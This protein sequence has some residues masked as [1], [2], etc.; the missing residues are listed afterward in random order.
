[1]NKNVKIA[2][3][4]IKLAKSLVATQNIANQEG[5]Y[6]NF[7]GKIDW[8]G[9]NGKVINATFKLVTGMNYDI[10]WERGTWFNGVW[11]NGYWKDGVWERGTWE[12]TTIFG[13]TWKNGFW[14]DGQWVNGTW[15]N[16]VW[17]RGVW[18]GGKWFYG[19]DKHNNEH[20]KG[21]SP[22]KW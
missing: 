1:M 14:K 2:K 3:E 12:S 9:I 5:E 13:S 20:E 6:K 22:D 17:E 19:K 8:K 18:Q 15:F 7:T 11:K 21:D 16:G 10:I 4:L